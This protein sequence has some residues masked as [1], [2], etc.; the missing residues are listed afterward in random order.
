MQCVMWQYMMYAVRHVAIY[1]VCSV[2]CGNMMYAVLSSSVVNQKILHEQEVEKT[3]IQ[4][5][6]SEV[7]IL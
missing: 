1:D 5:L 4:L 2:S 7:H 6:S 3:F